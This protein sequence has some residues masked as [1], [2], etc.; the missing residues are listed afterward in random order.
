MSH[1]SWGM[2]Q[3]VVEDKIAHLCFFHLC[4][5][6]QSMIA[7]LILLFDICTLSYFTSIAYI[8]CRHTCR[9]SKHFQKKQP[10]LLFSFLFESKTVD[11]H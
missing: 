2:S 8:T 5:I 7:S 3:S 6:W 1:Y 10:F 9:N 4:Q 11:F